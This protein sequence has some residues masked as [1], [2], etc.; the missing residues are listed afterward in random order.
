MG[1]FKAKKNQ[2]GVGVVVGVGGQVNNSC[3]LLGSKFQSATNTITRV[4]GSSDVSGLY[5]EVDTVRAGEE[6]MEVVVT[7][8][9]DHSVN[10][11]E[12]IKFVAVNMSRKDI[13]KH[14]EVQYEL[15][16]CIPERKSAIRRPPNNDRP[17]NEC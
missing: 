10:V 6:V 16:D 3:T 4:V 5:V 8:D 1:Q 15:L 9:W 7:N 12:M 17:R 11:E 2:I 13:A 14:E